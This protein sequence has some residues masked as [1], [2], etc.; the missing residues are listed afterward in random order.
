MDDNGWLTK[1]EIAELL[2]G[3]RP[4]A[5]VTPAGAVP[6]WLNN[7]FDEE[8]ERMRES[9]KRKVV[10]GEA[11]PAKRR[12]AARGAVAGRTKKAMKEQR[13][14]E[15]KFAE[16]ELYHASHG[17]CNVPQKGVEGCGLPGCGG[18]S[19]SKALG[20]WVDKQR[21][22]KKG[23][24]SNKLTQ[25]RIEKLDGLGFQWE[26][27]SLDEA[28]W[29]RWVAELKKYRE[30]HGN[31]RVPYQHGDGAECDMAGCEGAQHK[32]LGNWVSHQRKLKRKGS[33]RMTPA[34]IEELNS[35]P[36]WLWD[37]RKKE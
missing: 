24:G 31:C 10:E 37:V 12:R 17:D 2:A 6:D 36:G 13:Q 3:R 7:A 16:L 4:D 35:I 9:K 14:W 1:A 25:E 11:P 5:P 34:R 30:V 29:G 8:E 20:A 32:A 19:H 21:E 15:A 22:A 26:K 18:A 23:N 28:A 33:K 27:G